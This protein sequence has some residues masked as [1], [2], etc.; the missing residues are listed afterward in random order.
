[1]DE[2]EEKPIAGVMHYL[3]HRGVSYEWTRMTDSMIVD[4]INELKLKIL[5][6]ESKIIQSAYDSNGQWK[7]CPPLP[8]ACGWRKI[9]CSVNGEYW[10]SD[11]FRSHF[12]MS[13]NVIEQGYK[14]CP[15]CGK[16]IMFV[17]NGA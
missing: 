6:L 15:F 13:S 11:C 3:S 4:R 7:Q 12:I 8:A 16:A 1:M 9:N 10:D 17:S 2:Y 14:Y 5:K